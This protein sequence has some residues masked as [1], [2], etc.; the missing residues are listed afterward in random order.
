MAE[1]KKIKRENR[2]HRRVDVAL[3]ASIVL[4]RGERYSART[5]DVSEG[6]ILIE[7][8]RGPALSEGRLVGIDLQG[9]VSD[10][11]SD[12]HSQLL[13]RVVRQIDDKVAL[14]FAD[15]G[16]RGTKHKAST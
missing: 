10:E 12:E 11:D 3:S 9:V 1:T 6:G 14:R 15:S 5:V 8:Y 13:M 16:S 2:Q 4:A 7:N